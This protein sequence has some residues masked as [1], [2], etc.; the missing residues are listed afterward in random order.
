MASM[1]PS[2]SIGASEN[3]RLA[4]HHISSAANATNAGSPYVWARNLLANR[5]FECPVIYLE[6]YV[7]N[8]T[9]VHARVQAGDYNGL[10]E[11]NS[12]KRE[13]IFSEYV[14]GVVDGLV[15]YYG[16]R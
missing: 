16:K 13:S 1:A 11:I 5:L 4:E 10:R 14:R 7:M 15:A 8:N 12:A 3:A 2:V 9:D 6:P